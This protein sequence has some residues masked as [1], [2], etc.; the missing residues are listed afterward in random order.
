[1]QGAP[2]EQGAKAIAVLA[3]G[4]VTSEPSGSYFSDGVATPPSGAARDDKMRHALWD[5]TVRLAKL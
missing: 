3:G 1:V 4:E 2:V 5:E